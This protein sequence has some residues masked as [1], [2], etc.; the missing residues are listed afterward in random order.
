M[1]S[2]SEAGA[3]SYWKEKERLN[4]TNARGKECGLRPPSR[5]GSYRSRTPEP[6]P[7]RPPPPVLNS[8]Q[9]LRRPLHRQSRRMSGKSVSNTTAKWE[10]AASQNTTQ[11]RSTSHR[12]IGQSN[13]NPVVGM[14][15][16]NSVDKL[17]S[18]SQ[19]KSHSFKLS[20]VPPPKRS[21]ITRGSSNCSQLPPE[22]G[23]KTK[24]V[25]ELAKMLEPT[26]SPKSTLEYSKKER[27]P[28][29]LSPEVQCSVCNIYM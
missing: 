13:S 3:F 11:Q 10:A 4:D 19:F 28:S 24:S 18:P 1:A 21:H 23:V 7:P 26:L 5:G 27:T 20:P 6:T 12:A 16:Q 17:V 29:P 8:Q 22:Q 15:S 14:S 2:D 25:S 9:L